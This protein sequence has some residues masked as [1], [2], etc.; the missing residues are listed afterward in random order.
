MQKLK[1]A[2]DRGCGQTARKTSRILHNVAV[3]KAAMLVKVALTTRGFT[4]RCRQDSSREFLV[5]Q[6]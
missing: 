6:W 3:R 1:C 5:C 4:P 2:N